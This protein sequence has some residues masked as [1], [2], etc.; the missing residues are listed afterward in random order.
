MTVPPACPD[1]ADGLC[2]CSLAGPWENGPQ[3]GCI[4]LPPPSS[5]LRPL[6]VRLSCFLHARRFRHRRL[7]CCGGL[8]GCRR[9][10][11]RQRSSRWCHCM[12]HGGELFC[13]RSGEEVGA[14]RCER[15]LALIAEL[16]GRKTPWPEVFRWDLSVRQ[17][18]LVGSSRAAA[19]MEKQKLKHGVSRPFCCRF[20]ITIL[21]A[22]KSFLGPVLMAEVSEFPRSKH[23]FP[24]RVFNLGSRSQPRFLHSCWEGSAD[25]CL[26]ILFPD[27]ACRIARV[28]ATALHEG[29]AN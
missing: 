12:E 1:S 9:C 29:F 23:G 14:A 13:F 19:E 20:W 16:E 6:F 22:V 21:A 5:S 27:L 15:G 8:R 10:L 3:G 11:E 18:S 7:S 2:W 17:R 4:L 28:V 25:H 24:S 26:I